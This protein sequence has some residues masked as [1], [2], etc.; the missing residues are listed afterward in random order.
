MSQ[1]LGGLAGVE[2][3][4]DEVLVHG[5]DQEDQDKRLEAVLA[6]LLEAG[7]TLNLAK[8]EFSTNLVKLLGAD[9]S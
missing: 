1:S 4:T 5:R 6:R 2:C 8:S 3:N 7:V 9:T